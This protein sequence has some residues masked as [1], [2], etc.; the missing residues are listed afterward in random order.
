VNY[1]YHG[2]GGQGSAGLEKSF[3]DFRAAFAD[4]HIDVLNVVAERDMVVIYT[5]F[6]GTQQA[7]FLGIPSTGKAIKTYTIDFYRIQ[8]G[9]ISDHWDVVDYFAVLQ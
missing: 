3:A 4:F 5:T 8:N 6:T 2:L 9:Q 1:V 7:P